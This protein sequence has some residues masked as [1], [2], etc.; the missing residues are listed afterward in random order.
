MT[1]LMYVEKLDFVV[2]LDGLSEGLL[3]RI[4]REAGL[5]SFSLWLILSSCSE[6]E[7]HPLH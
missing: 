6:V 5:C 2:F 1:L 3:G 7:S 4:I